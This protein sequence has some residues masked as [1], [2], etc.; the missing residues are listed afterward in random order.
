MS[1]NI[2]FQYQPW[3]TALYKAR[4]SWHTHNSLQEIYTSLSC[5]RSRPTTMAPRKKG[6][7][8]IAT[9]T[10]T[11]PP[12]LAG[13]TPANIKALKQNI[14]TEHFGWAPESFAKQGNDAAN[15][16]MYAASAIVE[17]SLS[18]RFRAIEDAEGVDSVNVWDEE[19][20]SLVRSSTRV[21]A[22]RYRRLT[23][24]MTRE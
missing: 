5:K 19:E 11:L 10:A 4:R 3:S 9:P 20:I 21:Q 6:S 24:T 16:A 17:N 18:A 14:L 22:H 7:T 13:L 1:H 2:F 15:N 8:A 12:S 23:M